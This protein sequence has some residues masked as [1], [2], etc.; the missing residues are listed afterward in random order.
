[1]I[2]RVS[3]SEDILLLVIELLRRVLQRFKTNSNFRV[4]FTKNVK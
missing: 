4:S 1:M 2:E 3:L